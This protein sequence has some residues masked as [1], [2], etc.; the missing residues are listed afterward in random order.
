[1]TLINAIKRKKHTEKLNFN[2]MFKIENKTEEQKHTRNLEVEGIARED[3]VD[4]L[5]SFEF[6]SYACY[7]SVSCFFFTRLFE[8]KIWAWPNLIGRYLK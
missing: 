5:R 2:T 7:A 1:M 6:F 4:I 3:S 8:D